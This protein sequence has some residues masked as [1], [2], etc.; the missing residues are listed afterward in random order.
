M[1]G[2]TS[3]PAIYGATSIDIVLFSL[4][5]DAGGLWRHFWRASL[6]PICFSG[7]RAKR[8]Q[9]WRFERLDALHICDVHQ[10]QLR[11]A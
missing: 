5:C 3:F 10:V 11:V 4:T 2:M 1:T 9:L 6:R 7:R 8:G